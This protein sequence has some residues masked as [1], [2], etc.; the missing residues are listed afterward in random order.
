MRTGFAASVCVMIVSGAILASCLVGCDRPTAA[1]EIV[2]AVVPY[3]SEKTLHKR[4]DHFATYLSEQLGVKVRVHVC[5]DYA[6]AIEA[7]RSGQAQLASLGV[8]P[9]LIARREVGAIPL[10][11]PVAEG[12]QVYNSVIITRIDSGITDVS[13]L[14][15]RSFAFVDPVSTSGYLF[16]MVML[17]EAGL[18][19]GSD[20]VTPM[21][22]GSHQA[23]LES[24][25]SGRVDAGGTFEA[26]RG[27]YLKEESAREQIRVLAT[28]ADIPFGVLAAG[29]SLS[30]ETRERVCEAIEKLNATPDNA[31][32]AG[33]GLDAYIHVKPDAFDKVADVA[34]RLGIRVK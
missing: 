23:V 1:P 14:K 6:V 3:E 22:A 25:F 8:L 26:A 18:K 33:M 34:T 27:L 9:F 21:Y 16:P 15:D 13:Q 31:V 10:F 30:K 5:S 28:S 19:P 2:L 12:K 20:F 29:P 32:Y 4:Y 7:L 11:A 17:E 24:V